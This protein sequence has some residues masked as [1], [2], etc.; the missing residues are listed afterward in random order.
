VWINNGEQRKRVPEANI[1]DW[2][3]N[4]WVRGLMK[5][6]YKKNEIK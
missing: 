6:G 5:A 2:V 3:L 1:N 4:G